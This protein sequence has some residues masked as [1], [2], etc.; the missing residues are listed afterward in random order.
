MKTSDMKITLEKVTKLVAPTRT[1]KGTEVTKTFY[2]VKVNGYVQ[3]VFLSHEKDLAEKYYKLLIEN[4]GKTETIDV[5]EITTLS[6][7]SKHDELE[8]E[9]D[10]RVGQLMN[11]QFGSTG[12]FKTTGCE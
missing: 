12:E 10:E 2:H 1:E 3:E 8:K 7:R 4:A 11:S 6:P 5:L 9:L